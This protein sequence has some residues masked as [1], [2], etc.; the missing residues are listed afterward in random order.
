MDRYQWLL[1]FLYLNKREPIDGRVKLVKEMFLCK[2]E[3][4]GLKKLDFYDFSPDLYGPKSDELESDI[5]S[6]AKKGLI[7]KSH[8]SETSG[9]ITIVRENYAITDKGIEQLKKFLKRMDVNVMQ[10]MEKLKM[11]YNSLS[12]TFILLHVHTK[13]PSYRIF[14]TLP[15][16]HEASQKCT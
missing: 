12:D 15:N 13:Y 16:T 6:C 14:G 2:S 7:K 8:T 4:K 10:K 3:I 11:L 1:L 5:D 9:E